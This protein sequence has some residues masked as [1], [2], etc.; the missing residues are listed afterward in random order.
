MSE[1][2]LEI[3]RESQFSGSAF[4]V[5]VML[6]GYTVGSLKSGDVLRVPVFPGQHNLDFCKYGRVVNSFPFAIMDGQQ[7]AFY[8]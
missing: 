8:S 7:H 4:P 3:S 1:C 2:M 5:S 6:D